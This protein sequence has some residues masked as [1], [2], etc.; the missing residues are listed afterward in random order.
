MIHVPIN[1]IT[2]SLGSLALYVFSLKS[3]WSYRRTKNPLAM[4]Y[5][6]IGLSFGTA[7]FF[8]GV[9]GLF[10]QNLKILRYAYFLA[11][12]FVQI[13]M[14]I[15]L[16][17]LWFLGLRNRVRLDYIYVVTIPF[18]A[19]LMT[20]QALTSQV[21][22]SLSPYLIVYIDQ[23]PVLILKSII[24]VGVAMPIGYFLIRQVPKQI[25]LRSRLKTFMSGMTFI[26]VGLAA[27]YNNVFDRGSDTKE[28]ATIIAIF[29]V[30]FLLVQLLRPT[31]RRNN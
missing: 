30:I 14:Q 9:P 27:T 20:L 23:T 1:S 5:C 2:W 12:L 15:A 28:S 19:V 16:W 4:M 17:L 29:F 8:Y 11:D 10:T 25:S 31:G 26:V 22:L 18:S 13:T 6:M 24:Y 3:W 7:M 21:G